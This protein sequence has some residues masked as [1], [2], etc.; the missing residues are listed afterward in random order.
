MANQVPIDEST[1][2]AALL[3]LYPE[4][5]DVLIGIAP[6]FKKLRNRVLSRSVA[7]VAS[8]R[9]AAAVARM[10]AVELVNRLWAE[11]GQPPIDQA[12]SSEDTPYL[13]TRSECGGVNRRAIAPDDG[14]MPLVTLLKRANDLQVSEIIEL[15]SN[16]LPAP[17]IDAMR[18]KGFLVWTKEAEPGKFRTYF[19]KPMH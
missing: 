2:V 17:G 8:L 16:F 13:G 12:D 3:D 7:K 4:L 15:R 11:V 10:S 18:K 19:R 1:K 14:P 9:Q 5:E 6:P